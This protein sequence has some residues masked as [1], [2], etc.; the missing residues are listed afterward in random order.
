MVAM[1][2][3]PPGQ[4]DDCC[5]LG[6]EGRDLG[7]GRE[8]GAEVRLDVAAGVRLFQGLGFWIPSPRYRMRLSSSVTTF[9]S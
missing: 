7:D 8:V 4:K 1:L 6:R 2:T 3:R 5:V 9:V